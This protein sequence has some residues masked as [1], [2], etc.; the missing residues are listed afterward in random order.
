[1]SL[2]KIGNTNGDLRL[3]CVEAITAVLEHP[4]RNPVRVNTGAVYALL[5]LHAVESAPVMRQ[6]YHVDRVDKTMVGDWGDVRREFKLER[7]E[8]DPPERPPGKS[9]WQGTALEAVAKAVQL[10]AKATPPDLSLRP[11]TP[12]KQ[13]EA[14]RAKRK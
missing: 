10:M 13:R 2:G 6:A 1:E 7:Q 12:R 9:L 5:D 14:T 11:A 8:D 3:P 4:E